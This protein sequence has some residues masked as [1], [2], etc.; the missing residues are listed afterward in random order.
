MFDKQL[1]ATSLDSLAQT[2]LPPAITDAER[3]QQLLEQATGYAPWKLI[4]PGSVVLSDGACEMFGWLPTPDPLPLQEMVKLYQPDDR[5]KL[6]TLIAQALEGRR[7]FHCRL[8]IERRD[9]QVRMIETIADLRMVNGRVAELFGFSRD[10]TREME[11]ELQVQGRLKLVQELVGDMPAPIV[12]LD[13]KLRVMDCSIFWL[14]AHRFIEK[15]EV[16]GKS[17]LALTPNLPPEHKD[18]YERALKGQT[19][20]TRRTFTSSTSNQAIH[21]NTL[22]APWYVADRK[23]GGITVM[24]GWSELALARP[25]TINAA[26]PPGG[27]DPFD[28]SLLDLLKSVS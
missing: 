19:V 6:L 5:G 22:I 1:I 20:R 13:E 14:K 27:E 10:A 28:G 21:F 8:R 26:V 23:V 17:L 4:F 12:V 18:E 9:G 15:R 24:T 2:D 11:R 16:V 3:G 7:G 25:N